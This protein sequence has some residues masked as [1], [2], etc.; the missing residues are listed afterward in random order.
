MQKTPTRRVSSVITSGSSPSLTW[1]GTRYTGKPMRTVRVLIV[2]DTAGVRRSLRTLLPLA[3]ELK[4][5]KVEIAGEAA[6]GHEAVRLAGELRP[7]LVLMDLNMPGMD[8]YGAM[9]AIKS[10]YPDTKIL[11]LSV[12]STQEAR[13]KAAQAGADGFIEKGSP[14]SEI[15][16][17]IKSLTGCAPSVIDEERIHK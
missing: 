10:L 4:A 5:L 3:G 13:Q 14:V 7:D 17:N 12:H 15:I 1:S 2:D 8:G 6:D 9:Q 11:V 16:H